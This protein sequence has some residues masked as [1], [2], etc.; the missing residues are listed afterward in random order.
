MRYLELSQDE[1]LGAHRFL[2]LAVSEAP[3]L[4]CVRVCVCACVCVCILQRFI[5]LFVSVQGL[6]F[7]LCCESHVDTDFEIRGSGIGVCN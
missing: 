1:E 2:C 4:F 5:L 6:V 7:D 3:I